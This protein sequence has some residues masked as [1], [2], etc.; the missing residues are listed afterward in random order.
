M[1]KSLYLLAALAALAACRESNMAT[2]S[3][4]SAGEAARVM[5]FDTTFLPVAQRSKAYRYV[6]EL[7]V[8]RNDKTTT[9][10]V[11]IDW[12]ATQSQGCPQVASVQVY[13][14]N[15]DDR[16]AAISA[17]VKRDGTCRAGL[18]PDGKLGTATT[19]MALV[20]LS[21]VSREVRFTTVTS[22]LINALGYHDSLSYDN[23]SARR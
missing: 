20:S 7:R 4:P 3:T 10:P 13:Q 16:R 19:G 2:Q 23:A 21:G 8:G 1:K 18:G 15:G 12:T 22:C 6:T 9:I 17:S 11:E 5:R 14:L